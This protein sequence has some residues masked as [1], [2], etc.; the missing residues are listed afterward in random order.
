MVTQCSIRHL[1]ASEPKDSIVLEHAKAFERR[2]CNHHTLEQP[3]STLECLSSVVD[4]KGTKINKHRLVVASQDDTVR[5]FLRKIPGVPLIYIKRSVMIMEPMS[6]ATEEFRNKEELSKRRAGLKG[7]GDS[8]R[9]SKRG[10]GEEEEDISGDEGLGEGDSLDKKSEP[11]K[12]KR[13]RG[14]SEP[15]PLSIRKAK[16]PATPAKSK[17]N[18]QQPAEQASGTKTLA[19][20]PSI[21]GVQAPLDEVAKRKRKRKHKSVKENELLAEPTTTG[22]SVAK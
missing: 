10:R 15:N 9:G 16:K 2:R 4:P 3:L 18:A 1:Y 20:G 11:A 17:P 7:R 5:G 19:V 13:K 6:G 12:K 8:T 21:P 14:P 22:D